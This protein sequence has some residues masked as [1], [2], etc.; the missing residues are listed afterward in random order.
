MARVQGF[1]AKMAAP[2]RLSRPFWFATLVLLLGMVA[3][4]YLYSGCC[5]APLQPIRSD[6]YGYYAYLT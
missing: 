6:A 2:G 3:V 5:M 1:S 4:I